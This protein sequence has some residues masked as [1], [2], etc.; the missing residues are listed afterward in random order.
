LVSEVMLQQT[1]ASR[2]VEPWRKFIQRFPTARACADAS[3]ADV[4][5]AWRGLG[6]N[7][8]A[9]SLRAAAIV[10]RDDFGGD[11]PSDVAQ[12]RSLPGIGEYTANA[13]ASFAFG[14]PV[15]VLDTNV[16]RV[17]ARAVANRRL[18]A[19]EARALAGEVLPARDTASFNQAMIDL[20]AQFCRSA[21][22]CETCPL[23][24]VCVWRR[25]GGDD[26]AVMSA[27]VSQPQSKFLGSDRQLRG[28]VLNVLRDG[29]RTSRELDATFL[30]VMPDRRSAVL[31]SL[32]NDGLI[33]TAGKRYRLATS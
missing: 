33:A 19:S 16:G 23:R 27:G 6:Y 26:P 18:R 10:I 17:L 24:R 22:R 30:D 32:V 2:V 8:R 3:L 25:D 29:P 13:V 7:R 20:G 12:L 11:V 5:T 21:P 28:Q 31:E 15:A 1:Q 14:V 9:K 4:L